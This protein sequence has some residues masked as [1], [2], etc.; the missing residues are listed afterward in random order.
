MPGYLP[1]HTH[2]LAKVNID[3][4]ER[5]KEKEREKPRET[6]RELHLLNFAVALLLALM[7]IVGKYHS[8]GF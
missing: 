6:I 2:T 3:T 1:K 7:R 4:K 5:E 8:I